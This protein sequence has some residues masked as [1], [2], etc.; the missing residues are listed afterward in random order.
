MGYRELI[1]SLRKEGEENISRLWIDVQEEADKINA[2]TSQKI[3]EIREKYRKDQETAAGKQE[4]LILSETKNRARLIK[5]SAERALSDRLFP[6]AMS[7]L[8]ELRN[9]AYKDVFA[10]LVKE[11]PHTLWRE[12]RVNP[13]DITIAREHFPD[14]QVIPDDTISGGL[15]V[16]REDGRICI[17]NTFNKRLEK[18]WEDVLPSL[19]TDI[20]KE[21]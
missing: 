20:Y 8:H 9:E 5:L 4:D 6:L 18:A 7:Y 10:S 13:Q 1:E 17:A 3:E 12:V 21:V 14:S 19:I 2:E 11:L 15:E 16:I